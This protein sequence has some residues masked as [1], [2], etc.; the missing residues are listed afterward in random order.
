MNKTIDYTG[1]FIQFQNEIKRNHG[2]SFGR[3]AS[4]F[5]KRAV[6]EYNKGLKNSALE[7]AKLALTQAEYSGE[8]ITVYINGF[9]AQLYAELN[10]FEVAFGF[11]QKA[12]GQ[13]NKADEDYKEDL[14][15]F[16]A[17]KESIIFEEKES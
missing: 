17:L 9:L 11:C 3:Q 6:F 13:L 8:Y 5:F 2:N 10:Q 14:Q 7:T 15:Y 1:D 16:T 12:L 4:V